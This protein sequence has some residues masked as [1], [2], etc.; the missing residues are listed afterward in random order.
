M[1]KMKEAYID[2]LNTA[3]NYILAGYSDEQVEQT[4]TKVFGPFFVPYQRSVIDEA[5]KDVAS[6]HNDMMHGVYSHEEQYE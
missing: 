4:L 5:K 6:Y 3:M 2:M 1:S